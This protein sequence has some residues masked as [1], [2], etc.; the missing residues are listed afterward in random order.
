MIKIK[1]LIGKDHE[2]VRCDTPALRWTGGQYTSI[3]IFRSNRSPSV[4]AKQNVVAGSLTGINNGSSLSSKQW[5]K[6]EP[7]TVR[8]YFPICEPWIIPSQFE[9]C[10]FRPMVCEKS[11][12]SRNGCLNLLKQHQASK[13]WSIWFR[14]LKPD[15]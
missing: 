9:H 5:A 7:S 12:E 13:P 3:R 2:G 15:L 14:L 4:S 11:I 10:D 8:R 6:T 1:S